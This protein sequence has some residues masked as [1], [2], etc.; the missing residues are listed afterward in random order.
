MDVLV[1]FQAVASV[2][3]GRV[4]DPAHPEDH[5]NPDYLSATDPWR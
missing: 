3:L 1:D 4:E 5:A 2:V